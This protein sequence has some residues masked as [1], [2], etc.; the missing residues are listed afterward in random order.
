[1]AR[2]KGGLQAYVLIWQ[3]PGSPA[4]WA[5][6]NVKTIAQS[7]PGVRVLNDVNGEESRRFGAETS[8]HTVLFTATGHL[9]FSGGITQSRGHEGDNVGE[10]AIIS[11]LDDEKMAAPRS[12]SVFGCRFATRP[13]KTDLW[14]K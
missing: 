10:S 3:P 11:L 6:T 9:L 5:N 14:S 2:A 1:M 8:G 4:D 7:I 13:G 12:T